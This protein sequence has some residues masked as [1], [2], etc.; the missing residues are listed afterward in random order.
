M[1]PMLTGGG[2]LLG[3]CQVGAMSPY[4]TSV[5]VLSSSSPLCLCLAFLPFLYHIIFVASSFLCSFFP[6]GWNPSSWIFPGPEVRTQGC[7]LTPGRT[8]SQVEK[9]QHGC[10]ICLGSEQ[11]S[12]FSCLIKLGQELRKF[13]AAVQ[14]ADQAMIPNPQKNEKLLPILGSSIIWYQGAYYCIS[15]RSKPWKVFLPEHQSVFPHRHLATQSE[16]VPGW[17]RQH[18]DD[19]ALRIYGTVNNTVIRQYLVHKQNS[20]SGS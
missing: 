14:N 1:G 17:D 4:P 13:W 9:I 5:S 20:W 18:G 15:H 7:T 8:P 2:L 19:Q 12:C 3:R 10:L 6:L 16:W 11:P